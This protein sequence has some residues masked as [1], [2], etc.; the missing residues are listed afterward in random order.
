M[1]KT[2]N[3]IFTTVLFTL[4]LSACQAT[5]PI[6]Q[7]HHQSVCASLMRLNGT[8]IC[9]NNDWVQDAFVDGF[10]DNAKVMVILNSAGIK[11]LQ[12]KTT[13]TTAQP[14][15]LQI[16][17]Q[18]FE[19]FDNHAITSGFLVLKPFNNRQE[20]NQVVNALKP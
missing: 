3:R 8:A 18:H 16:G 11:A 13:P 10:G 9:M 15:T 4:A 6:E 7:P 5:A 12:A 19:S 17:A 14:I 2:S 1:I 20:A